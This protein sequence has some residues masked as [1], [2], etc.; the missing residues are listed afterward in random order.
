MTP[1]S[2]PPLPDRN[3]S[4]PI[5]KV[6]EH[7]LGVPLGALLV[8]PQPQLAVGLMSLANGQ[9]VAAAIGN[10]RLYPSVGWDRAARMGIYAAASGA[11]A[12]GLQLIGLTISL[13][14]PLDAQEKDVV[15]FWRRIHREAE[16]LEVAVLANTTSVDEAGQRPFIGVCTA[17]AAGAKQGVVSPADAHDGDLLVMT[18]SA[19]IEAAAL[20]SLVRYDDVEES[21]GIGFAEDAIEMYRRLSTVQDSAIARNCVGL[22]EGRITSMLN[23]GGQGLTQALQSLAEASGFGVEMERS[24]AGLSDDVDAICS[25]FELDPFATASQGVLLLTCS[26]SA[27]DSLRAGF[28]AGGVPNRVFG[29]ISKSFQG[30]RILNNGKLLETIPQ[31][32]R[33]LSQ[34]LAETQY[35]KAES[36]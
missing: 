34:I 12:T 33:T 23:V 25:H 4:E 3:W 24:Q 14:L 18:K 31:P 10:F 21:F 2:E 5:A 9:A 36:G 32:H 19:G 11:A 15:D 27:I 8:E 16:K 17:L 1:E 30:V 35:E 20:L 26:P 13:C 22:G 6:V 7:R 29:R 28:E